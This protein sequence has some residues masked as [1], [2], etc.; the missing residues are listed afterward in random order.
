MT[1]TTVGLRKMARRRAHNHTCDQIG[2][3]S[4]EPSLCLIRPHLGRSPPEF[5]RCFSM[6]PKF[7]FVSTLAR[8]VKA[9]LTRD[10]RTWSTWGR[11][12]N[13][14]FEPLLGDLPTLFPPGAQQHSP[15]P[16]FPGQTRSSPPTDASRSN[17]AVELGPV[18]DRPAPTE[19]PR[20][21]GDVQGGGV[22][23]AR[24]LG[25]GG[26]AQLGQVHGAAPPSTV[27]GRLRGALW[28]AAT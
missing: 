16:P 11:F 6:N 5:G 10:R 7:K 26:C 21:G 3:G 13:P 27:C 24:V 15:P 23:V 25:G 14:D 18:T 12:P 28:G 8:Q 19:T 22:G 1:C 20:R 17:S 4:A 2:V 9:T